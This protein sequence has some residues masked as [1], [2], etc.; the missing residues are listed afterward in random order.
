MLPIFFK[1][2]GGVIGVSKDGEIAMPFNTIGM[3]RAAADH[4]GI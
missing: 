4:K 2:D 3:F 1:D